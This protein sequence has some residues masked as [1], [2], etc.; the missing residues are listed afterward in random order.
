MTEG[1]AAAA[2][3]GATAVVAAAA[4]ATEVVVAAAAGDTPVATEIIGR[5]QK[6][7]LNHVCSALFVTVLKLNVSVFI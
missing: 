5:G 7:N 4:A 2:A 6:L 1:S 3:T